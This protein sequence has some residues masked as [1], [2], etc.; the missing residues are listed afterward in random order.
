MYVYC[1]S[2]NIHLIFLF[3]LF[4]SFFPF[5]A[6][7]SC[8]SLLFLKPTY[9]GHLI[10]TSEQTLQAS[11]CLAL[12]MK[13]RIPRSL[14]TS[15]GSLVVSSSIRSQPQ[16]FWF[17]VKCFL[18]LLF[19]YIFLFFSQVWLMSPFLLGQGSLMAELSICWVLVWS[20]QPLTLIVYSG[21]STINFQSN[22][23]PTYLGRA[24]MRMHGKINMHVFL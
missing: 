23:C 9:M 3:I 5:N 20:S 19:S 4:H 12:W 2:S 14:V 21:V 24:I 1:C 10:W 17:I 6:T 7:H 8:K 22:L 16:I 11:H 15:L 18:S 13:N